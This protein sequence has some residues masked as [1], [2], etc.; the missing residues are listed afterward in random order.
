MRC[1]QDSFRQR[2]IS[3]LRLHAFIFTFVIIIMASL[4]FLT[5]AFGSTAIENQMTIVT[6]EQNGQQLSV[7]V[8][9]T[10]SVELPFLGSAGY[11]WY[12]ENLDT[13]HLELL[14]EDTRPIGET[15]KIGG[16]V[17][18]VWR[19]RAHRPGITKIKMN[20]YR[21]WEG[22]DTAIDHFT[23]EIKIKQETGQ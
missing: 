4:L 12:I 21:A 22:V 13:D 6:R 23:V 7:P 10:I 18:G 1:N 17:L 14:H 20:Y 5:G 8:G 16:P 11:G 2:R 19:F 15:D 3:F 9:A